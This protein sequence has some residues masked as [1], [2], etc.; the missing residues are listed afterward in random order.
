MINAFQSV[1]ASVFSIFQLPITI[2]SFTFTLW[3]VFI[4][5]ILIGLVV[6]LV[7]GLLQ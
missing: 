2:D 7:R 1:M 4:A 6:I 5:S 3:H